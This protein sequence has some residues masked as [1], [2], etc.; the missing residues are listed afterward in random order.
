VSKMMAN[1][2][3]GKTTDASFANAATKRKRRARYDLSDS[4]VPESKETS[5][6][7]CLRL[8]RNILRR[9]RRGVPVGITRNHGG[10]GDLSCSPLP[11]NASVVTDREQRRR[12]DLTD[13]PPP[14]TVETNN[15]RFLRLG[16]NV[17]RRARRDS[18]RIS[19]IA[20][21]RAD[22]DVVDHGSIQNDSA[23]AI[24]NAGRNN[25]VTDTSPADPEDRKETVDERR[26][27]VDR[28]RKSHVRQAEGNSDVAEHRRRL[29]RERKRRV[30]QAEGN[31]DVAE[32]CRRLD[33]ERKRCALEGRPRHFNLQ[34]RLEPVV[35]KP[36]KLCKY[37]NK[38]MLYKHETHGFCCRSGKLTSLES[39]C[40]DIPEELL[41]VY[42]HKYFGAWSRVVNNALRFSSPGNDVPGG[43]FFPGHPG[44]LRCCGQT[45][46]RVLNG[47][48]GGP[49]RAWINDTS[50]QLHN[51]NKLNI[52]TEST[53]PLG[54]THPV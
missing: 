29:D 41:P 16:R 15:Q 34:K 33:R 43:M 3:S 30:R 49:L 40:F 7:R 42:E 19:E 12:S 45:Y 13:S 28:E 14:E 21:I 27:R 38:F 39:H 32:R 23:A 37:C 2:D 24:R 54:R 50:L 22:E 20:P 47:D 46:S 5:E 53:R 17:K 35:V 8:R 10:S 25:D 31:N 1:L 9:G 52:P 51:N 18:T 4:P 6:Q 11:E 26:R 36:E 44:H 48:V